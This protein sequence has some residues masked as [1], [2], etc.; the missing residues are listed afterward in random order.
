[1]EPEIAK[2]GLDQVKDKKSISQVESPSAN[3]SSPNGLPTKRRPVHKLLGFT[4]RRFEL[5]AS[6]RSFQ[7][8]FDHHTAGRVGGGRVGGLGVDRV[9]V[10]VA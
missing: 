3:I 9:A 10:H 8:E 1:M 5:V 7:C 4:E 2:T 6:R